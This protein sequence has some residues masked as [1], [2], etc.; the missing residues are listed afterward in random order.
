MPITVVS[1]PI[2]LSA[3]GAGTA[4]TRTVRGEVLKIMFGTPGTAL[5]TGG[6]AD[7]TVTHAPTGGTVLSVSNIS[8]GIN[9]YSPREPYHSIAGA[10]LGTADANGVTVAGSVTFT[11]AQGA[12]SAAGTAHMYVRI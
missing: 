11:I 7:L 9:T 12:L 4:T 10:V 2:T 5:L 8:P 6:S 3:S 1:V